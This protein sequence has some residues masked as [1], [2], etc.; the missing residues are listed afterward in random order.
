MNDVEVQAGD[1]RFHRLPDGSLRVLNVDTSCVGHYQCS[2]DN[3]VGVAKSRRARMA[4]EP[5]LQY[6]DGGVTPSPLLVDGRLAPQK[7]TIVLRP[8]GGKISARHPLVLHCSAIGECTPVWSDMTR[9]HTISNMLYLGQTSGQPEP[10]VTWLMNGRPL[11]DQSTANVRVYNNGTLVIDQPNMEDS[12]EY[13]C[14]AANYLGTVD[15]RTEVTVHGECV[16]PK[17]GF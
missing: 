14:N 17:G 2:A 7:P 6:D 8:E 1:S 13:R 10:L 9:R 12:G 16:L 4:L 11:G 3:S 15:A 5:L